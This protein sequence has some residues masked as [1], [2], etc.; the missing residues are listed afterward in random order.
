MMWQLLHIHSSIGGW[1]LKSRS[2]GSEQCSRTS[3][4]RLLSVSLVVCYSTETI[5]RHILHTHKTGMSA[6]KDTHT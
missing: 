4:S 1:A 5:T 3:L 6:R 2:D